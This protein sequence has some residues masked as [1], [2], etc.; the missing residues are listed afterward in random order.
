MPLQMIS[1]SFSMPWLNH[2]AWSQTYVGTHKLLY[3]HLPAT[4]A[5]LEDDDSSLCQLAFIGANHLMEVALAKVI[6]HCDPKFN[7]KDARYYSDLTKTLPALI[8]KSPNLEVE[9]FRSTEKLRV[10]RNKTIHATSAVVSVE[11]ARSALFSATHGSRALF[12][13]VGKP[14][15]YERFLSKRPLPEEMPF[16]DL[17]HTDA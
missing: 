12:E 10:R 7:M 2:D 8:G 1:A 3:R 4:T 6:L 16:F 13:L 5:Q 9:P 11:M 17:P 15:P 14:F